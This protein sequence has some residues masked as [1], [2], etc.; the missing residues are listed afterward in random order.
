MAAASFKFRAQIKKFWENFIIKI[1]L[2]VTINY[3]MQK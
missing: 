2:Y 1:E 3:K